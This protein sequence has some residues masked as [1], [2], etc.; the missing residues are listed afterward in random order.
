[1]GGKNRT[2]LCYLFLS[3]FS[4]FAQNCEQIVVR[5]AVI[6]ELPV[7]L[8]LDREISFE[9]FKPIFLQYPDRSI[10][11]HC[12]YILEEELIYDEETF[13][14][15]TSNQQLY[16]ASTEYSIVGFV[17]FHRNNASIIIDLLCVDKKHRGKGIGKQLVNRIFQVPNI[18]SY[19]LA[20]IEKN[21]NACAFW[22]SLGFKL[23]D[24]KPS[25]VGNDFP[26]DCADIYRYYEYHTTEKI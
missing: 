26:A 8:A 25:D 14:K 1:M 3:T 19:R 21:E 11:K 16:V 2:I 20:I 23:L 6:D 17:N 24:K 10:G 15:A 5:P 4:L 12:D 13:A 7:I 18:I 9:Y 22:K